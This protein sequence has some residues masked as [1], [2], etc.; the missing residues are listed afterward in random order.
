[1]LKNGKLNRMF[2]IIGKT[3]N[4]N[5]QFAYLKNLYLKRKEKGRGDPSFSSFLTEHLEPEY[6]YKN[7][8]LN[9][10]SFYASP[11]PLLLFNLNSQST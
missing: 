6:Y 5:L 3:Q 1:M 9:F 8:F 7:Y 11:T 10:R 4:W 2:K